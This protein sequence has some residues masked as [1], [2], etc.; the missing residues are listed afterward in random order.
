MP[1]QRLVREITRD[2]TQGDYRFQA[3]A[4]TA[5]QETAEAHLVTMFEGKFYLD[6][7]FE[8]VSLLT[9]LAANLCAI[10]A[11]RVT[12]QKRDIDLVRKLC[13]GWVLGQTVNSVIL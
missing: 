8:N 10:H 11:H 1:F 3:L 5:L 2:V 7:L 6:T 12:I 13:N 4:I 9:I